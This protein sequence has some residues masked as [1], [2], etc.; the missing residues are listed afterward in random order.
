MTSTPLEPRLPT[1][2]VRRRG[3]LIALVGL[4]LLLAVA[5]VR[6]L[7]APYTHL[8][9]AAQ[10]LEPPVVRNTLWNPVVLMASVVTEFWALGAVSRRLE[11]RG[12]GAP[13]VAF[14]SAL[15]GC[16]VML[17]FGVGRR[18]L[19][20]GGTAAWARMLWGSPL[21]GLEIFGIWILAFRYPELIDDARVRELEIARARQTAELVHLREHLEP[22]FLR[23]SLNTI[24]ALLGE[25]PAEARNLLGALGDLLTDSIATSGPERTLGEEVDWLRRYAAILE[26]R[27]RDTLSFVWDEEARTRTTLVPRLLLQPL[28]ENAVTHGALAREGG[29]RVTVRTRALP[30]GGTRVEIEDNGPGFDPARPPAEGLGLTLVRRRVELEARGTFR[31][32]ASPGGTR[33]V[34]ELA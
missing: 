21:G 29:G 26:A 10:F 9:F 13:R 16:G 2:S 12:A 33:A 34:V 14:T 32:E 17:L 11:R 24:A 19:E 22:H 15:V 27:H 7:V 30:S 18:L 25:D 5:V 31:L 28:L 3:R 6:E 1:P 20:G 8:P 4:S 23:N